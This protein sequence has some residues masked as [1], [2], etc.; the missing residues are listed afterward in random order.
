MGNEEKEGPKE[1]N[2]GRIHF[3]GGCDKA[4]LFTKSYYNC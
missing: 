4:S 3:G 2:I 1:N